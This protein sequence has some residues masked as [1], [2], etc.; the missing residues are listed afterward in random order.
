SAA[1]LAEGQTPP[2]SRLA[3][4]D[5]GK[6]QLFVAKVTDALGVE[7]GLIAVG[8]SKLFFRV[9]KEGLIIY[10]LD[11]YLPRRAQIK[12][13]RFLPAQEAG[14]GRAVVELSLQDLSRIIAQ[15]SMRVS[16]LLRAYPE[17][18]NERVVTEVRM[19]VSDEKAL[20]VLAYSILRK[21]KTHKEAL[22]VV[23][24]GV[25]GAI[26]KIV[27]TVPEWVALKGDPLPAAYQNVPRTILASVSSD[28][29][30]VFDNDP[31]ARYLFVEK[32]EGVYP[33]QD[34]LGMALFE[35]GMGE[36]SVTNPRF[37][38]FTRVYYSLAGHEVPISTLQRLS[39]GQ[40]RDVRLI[41]QNALR[42]QPVPFGTAYRMYAQ[43]AR[44]F[45]QAV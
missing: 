13:Y 28:K 6:T 36:L 15:N 33:F 3:E 1:G 23:A 16:D 41:L 44:Q 7:M 5:P 34:L 9:T 37:V 14:S 38:D 26:K 42:P 30:F 24:S 19:D 12:D 39:L 11:A 25:A 2:G 8:S 35:A 29:S 31:A 17:L 18:V 27:G 22:F 40:I 10:N 43:M 21:H 20:T 32:S 4:V 45:A